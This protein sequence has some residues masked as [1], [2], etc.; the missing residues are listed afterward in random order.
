MWVQAMHSGERIVFEIN[1]TEKTV[2]KIKPYQKMNSKLSKGLK[3]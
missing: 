3:V 1:G 2:L